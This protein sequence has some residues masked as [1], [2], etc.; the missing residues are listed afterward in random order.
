MLVRFFEKETKI[1]GSPKMNLDQIKTR[2]NIKVE[3]RQTFTKTESQ[4]KLK[5]E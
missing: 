1:M 5:T 3:Y 4:I 2:T